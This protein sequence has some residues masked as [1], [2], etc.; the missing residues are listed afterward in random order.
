LTTFD[1]FQISDDDFVK[2]RFRVRG[3]DWIH[4]S[5]PGRRAASY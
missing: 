1:R 3:I 5:S 2:I 4:G